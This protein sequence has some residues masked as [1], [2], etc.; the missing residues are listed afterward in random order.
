MVGPLVCV[1]K[2]ITLVFHVTSLLLKA[3]DVRAGNEDLMLIYSRTFVDIRCW[4][5]DSRFL[6]GLY[7]RS[8]PGF[9][10]RV[11]GPIPGD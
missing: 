6:G 10:I 3:E 9:V 2:P 8:S 11:W 4:T 7:R 1:T 5:S